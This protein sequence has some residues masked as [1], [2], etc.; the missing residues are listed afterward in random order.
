M[1]VKISV[2]DFIVWRIYSPNSTHDV[3]SDFNASF[4]TVLTLLPFTMCIDIHTGRRL[5]ATSRLEREV[6]YL[7]S[8]IAPTSDSQ[9]QTLTLSKRDL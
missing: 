5:Q 3:Q 7:L 9:H 8:I 6:S 2:L 1:D 4:S